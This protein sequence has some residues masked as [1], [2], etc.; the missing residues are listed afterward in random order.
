M[1]EEYPFIGKCKYSSLKKI[2][3]IEDGTSSFSYVKAANKI[4]KNL[5]NPCPFNIL[6][7]TFIVF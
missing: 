2:K 4:C 7:S 5:I 6:E 1:S 3:G